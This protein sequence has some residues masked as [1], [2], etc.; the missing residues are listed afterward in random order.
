MVT[1]EPSTVNWNL[2]RVVKT[3]ADRKRDKST[4]P[5]YNFERNYSFDPHTINLIQ[6]IISATYQRRILILQCCSKAHDKR[7]PVNF[8]RLQFHYILIDPINLTN[9]E[10]TNSPSKILIRVMRTCAIYL[11]R[12]ST[13]AP[14][15]IL[16]YFWVPRNL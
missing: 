16:T 12:L 7:L 3:I 4:S 2:M 8:R 13:R 9:C 1:L 6:L 5:V 15:F 10:L 11:L 14:R